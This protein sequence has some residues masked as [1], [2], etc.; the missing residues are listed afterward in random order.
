MTPGGASQ[1]IDI[2][3]PPVRSPVSRRRAPRLSAMCRY[4]AS[5]PCD[6]NVPIK[7]VS[8]LRFFDVRDLPEMLIAGHAHQFLTG[9]TTTRVIR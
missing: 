5:L 9:S 6:D 1:M 4:P 8:H 2:L 7:R 3:N